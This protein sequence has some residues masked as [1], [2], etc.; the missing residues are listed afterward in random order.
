MTTSILVETL[1]SNKVLNDLNF[2]RDSLVILDTNNYNLSFNDLG[3][4][5]NYFLPI[6]T[7][8]FNYPAV[9]NFP[10]TYNLMIGKKDYTLNFKKVKLFIKHVVHTNTRVIIV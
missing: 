1:A 10:S 7:A 3:F 8:H 4:N 6:N 9:I 5:R 2:I